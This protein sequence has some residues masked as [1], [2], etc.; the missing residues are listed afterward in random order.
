MEDILSLVTSVYNF[1]PTRFKCLSWHFVLTLLLDS[2]KFLLKRLFFERLEH[3]IVYN[4]LCF[5]HR[6]L[7]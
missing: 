5:I 6:P 7:E 3:A 4:A 2:R 1:P